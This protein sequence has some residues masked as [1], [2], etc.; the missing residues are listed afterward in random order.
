[1]TLQ[2]PVDTC[3]GGI[4]LLMTVLLT[5]AIA[6]QLNASML[7]PV[8]ATMARELGTDEATVGLTQTA[9]FTGGAMC[10]LFLPRLSDIVGRRKILVI[11]LAVMAIG[12]LM[13]ALA[14]NITVLA[15]A[16]ALQGISGP[17]IPMTLIILRSQV[18]DQVR[19]GTL[20]GIIAAVNGGIAGI[21][22]IASGWM[23]E[24][25]GFRSVF[26]LIAIV[27]LIATVVV[28]LWAPESKP[29]DNVKMD[30]VGAAILVVSVLSIT[31]AA[32]EAGKAAAANWMLVVGLILFGLAVF[33][34]FWKWENKHDQP[35]VAPKYLARRQTW[36]LLLTTVLTMTGVF[37]A[38]N[39]VAISLA[40]NPDAG[41][42]LPADLASLMLLTP[43][44]LIGWLVGPFAGR[45]APRIGYSRLLRI[46]N[47]SSAVLLLVL[48]LAGSTSKV[49]L[50][51]SVVLLGITYAGIGNIVLN[52]LGVVNSPADNEGFL[53][54]MNSAAFNLGAG[55][56]FAVLPV[57]MVAGSPAGSDSTAGYTTA[58]I[59]GAIIL[60][61]SVATSFF[62]PKRVDA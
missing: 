22:V 58:F 53:P 5:A 62:I 42:G 54:G 28:A 33:A 30:W 3:K 14:P 16:R 40:Q 6:F 41:F 32:N 24:H 37:A 4:A 44:A 31:L 7:S 55:I 61:L 60:G 59:V 2:D 20:M 10:G 51:A 46:G 21:D 12:G 34:V 52:N 26:W 19:L 57:F 29:S 50:I 18:R 56:S 38:V 27:G 15:I 9:F 13:A 11:M 36:G 47:A 48:A 25:L 23:A 8:L 39:G 1:M 43:Y 17:T 49:V 45:W 35:M